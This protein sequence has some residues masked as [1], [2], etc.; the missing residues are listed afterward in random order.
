MFIGELPVDANLV[1]ITTLGPCMRLLAQRVDIGHPSVQALSSEH[2]QFNF[3]HIQ[4]T[5]MF[6]RVVDFQT[7]E[8]TPSFGWR[9]VT[10][11]MDSSSPY[12]E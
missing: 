3:R 9:K 4:P 12:N 2:R 11:G 7:V 6:G 5:A 8:Q 10:N 1:G